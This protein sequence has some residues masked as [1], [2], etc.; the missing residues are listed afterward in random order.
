M[1]KSFLAFTLT[2]VGLAGLVYAQARTGAI[3]G[4]VTD[5]EGKP[6]PGVTVTLRSAVAGQLT[7]LLFLAGM[8]WKS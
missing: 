8:R 3:F 2:L 6:L 5:P 4:T 1:R 7:A